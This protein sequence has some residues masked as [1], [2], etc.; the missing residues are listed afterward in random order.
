M[1]DIEIIGCMDNTLDNTHESANRVYDAQ[2][3]SPTIPTCC[4]G[5]HQPKIMEVKK[6]DVDKLVIGGMQE[7]QS[8]KTDGIC[9]CL[10]S[11][12]GAGGGYVPMI[13]EKKSIKI[14]QATKDG[15]IDCEVGGVADLNYPESQTRRGRVIEKGKICPTLTTESIPSVIEFGNP[16]FY[17]FLYE[18]DGEIYLIRIRKLVPKECWR[19]MGF[20]DDDFDKAEKVN[21]NTQLYKQA[22][23]SIVVTVLEAIFRQMMGAK[24]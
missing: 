11:S 20:A 10:T 5:G 8:I 2:G 15:F 19:L 12:M 7:H 16:D 14:R 4:G 24:E 6:L 17:N 13:M 1:N 18:I 23:N 3:L 22:G 21:S 9:T